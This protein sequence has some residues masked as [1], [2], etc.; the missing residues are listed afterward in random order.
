MATLGPNELKQVALPSGFDAAYLTQMALKD[1]RTYE[2]YLNDLAT[3]ISEA[4]RNLMADPL[5]ASL[6]SVTDEASLEYAIGVS[7]GFEPHTEYGTPTG[8]RAATTGTMLPLNGYDRALSWTHDYLRNARTAQLDANVDSAV[9]DLYNIWEQKVLTRLFKSTYDSV[10]SGKSMPLADAGTAD[11]AYVPVNHPDRATAFAS[12]HD[13]IHH[14]NGITQTGLEEAIAHLWEHGHDAPYTLV[15]A[16]ADVGSWSNTTTVTGWIKKAATEI[17]YG[18]TTNLATV[19]PSYIGAIETSVYGSVL[20]RAS[21][22]IPTLFWAAYKSYGPGDA[23]NPLVV[24]QSADYGLGAVLLSGREYPIWQF[25]LEGAI[26]FF[27]FGVG[28]RDRVG[29]VARKNHASAYADPT[30]A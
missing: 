26:L 5:V 27:E 18:T 21:A 9:A 16:Q 19:D 30:I 13:H 7:N 6:V 24:R 8:K 14:Y 28:V 1:G 17:R 25:P 20:V 10:G 15:I 12:T 11:S 4:N 22:R 29:A 2:A 23:R 3:V